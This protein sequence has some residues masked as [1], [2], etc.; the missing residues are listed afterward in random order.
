MHLC[1]CVPWPTFCDLDE[2]MRPTLLIILYPHACSV[3]I[4]RY[5]P[6]EVL[7]ANMRSALLR[8]SS[9][10]ILPFALKET[11]LRSD[12]L[13]Y[14]IG[15]WF[16]NWGTRTPGGTWEV[17]RGYV[18]LLRNQNKTIIIIMLCGHHLHSSERAS[19]TH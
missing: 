7:A 18:E 8:E 19:K 6:L 4:F 9:R 16:P 3:Q 12:K 10:E 15:Q 1:D 11:L 17:S 13:C 14:N 2:L 5:S